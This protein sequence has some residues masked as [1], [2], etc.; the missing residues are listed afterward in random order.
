MEEKL[1][2]AL[3]TIKEQQEKIEE[4]EDMVQA[5]LHCYQDIER[6]L[7]NEDEEAIP[8]YGSCYGYLQKLGGGIAGTRW[9]RKW[10][11]LENDGMLYYWKTA[12]ASTDPSAD[13]AIITLAGYSINTSSFDTDL[14]F[15]LIGPHKKTYE[16]H[17]ES[18]EDKQRWVD[19]IS[20][21]LEHL[22]LDTSSRRQSTVRG[23][24]NTRTSTHR[25]NESPIGMFLLCFT[26]ILS[27]IFV[28]SCFVGTLAG[29]AT[30][31][32]LLETCQMKGWVL[33]YTNTGWARSFT[34]LNGDMLF[35]Y[36]S[37]KDTSG[38]LVLYLADATF[39][40]IS[41]RDDLQTFEVTTQAGATH[42]L[43]F[44]DSGVCK[45]WFEALVHSGVSSESQ[46]QSQCQSRPHPQIQPS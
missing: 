43:G 39:S 36:K 27:Y 20:Q 41:T 19:A 5:L 34:I 46:S 25:F 16:F 45:K 38:G 2:Q 8:R 35:I 10:C 12:A 31:P 29:Q 30:Q 23:R 28:Y 17:A 13:K 24:T 6:R 3:L 11:V 22:E 44:V 21:Y 42:T 18:R 4:L 1:D 37:N 40:P 7:D 32:S 15:R 14:S 26:V 33:R 9:K